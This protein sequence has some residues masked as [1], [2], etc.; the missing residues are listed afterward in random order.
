MTH[1][2]LD[3]GTNYTKATKDGKNV[4]IFPSI[5]VYGE[6][7]DW[8]LTGKTKDVYVGEEALNIAQSLENVEVFRPL[9]EGRI[10]HESY[11]ELARHAIETLKTKPS[12]VATGLPVKSSRKERE[13]LSESIKEKLGVEVL[14]FPEPVGTLAYMDMDTGVCV[15]IG[16]GTTDMIVLSGMEYL[17]GDTMLMGADWLFDNIEVIIRNKAGIGLTPEELTK[18]IVNEDYEIGRIRSGRRITIKHS[19]IE[20]DYRKLMRSWVERIASRVK[21]ML[22]GLSTAIVDNMVVTGGG[23]LLPGVKEA[24]EDAFKEIT[25]IKVPGNPIAANALGYYRLA[26]A[27]VKEER[28]ERSESETKERE[29]EKKETEEKKG[30][31]RKK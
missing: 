25:E 31:G 10:I 1:I 11:I 18:L 23:A 9:H 2:G 19:D 21:L 14:I 3:I 22:E 4:T 16:F 26:E 13:E 17:K 7:K 30:K 28:K 15:D 5:V 29:E 12:V 6:E 27:I 8:S 24:F 20:D